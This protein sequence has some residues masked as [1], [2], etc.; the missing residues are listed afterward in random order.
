MTVQEE[1]L[2][3]VG[4]RMDESNKLDFFGLDEVNELIQS[5]MAVSA[6]EK[7]RALMTKSGE[8]A[9][10]VRVKF[11]GFSVLVALQASSANSANAAD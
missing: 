7:G 1:K 10:S 4:L 2:V 5:G 6:V 11:E 3:E 8:S 9:E